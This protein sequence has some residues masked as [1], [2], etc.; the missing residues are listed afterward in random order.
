MSHSVRRYESD[1]DCVE[2]TDFF[3]CGIVRHTT[4][5][6]NIQPNIFNMPHISLPCH[7]RNSGPIIMAVATRSV[8]SAFATGV[9]GHSC[10]HL[11][12]LARPTSCHH[13]SRRQLRPVL[14]SHWSH[15]STSPQ[16]QHQSPKNGLNRLQ[17]Y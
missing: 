13:P 8:A 16:P 9:A 12:R 10:A 4:T 3:C 11:T 5:V 1:F 7:D 17:F 6:L 15:H 14:T 2:S